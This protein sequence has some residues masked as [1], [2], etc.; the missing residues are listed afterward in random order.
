M[1]Y[2]DHRLKTLIFIDRV[3]HPFHQLGFN[4]RVGLKWLSFQRYF[5]KLAFFI[6]EFSFSRHL[7]THCE[8]VTYALYQELTSLTRSV[9]LILSQG[10]LDPDPAHSICFCLLSFPIALNWCVDGLL[11][12]NY[13]ISFLEFHLRG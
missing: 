5:L 9:L 12:L 6:F 8:F 11:P 3:L 1:Y 2:F 10:L 13:A 7:V 4:N